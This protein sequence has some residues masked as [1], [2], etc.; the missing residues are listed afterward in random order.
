MFRK[1]ELIVGL[2]VIALVLGLSGYAYWL[3]K[4]HSRDTSA[5]QTLSGDAR[6]ATTYTREYKKVLAEETKANERMDEAL[7]RNPAWSDQPVPN[8]VADLLRDHSDAPE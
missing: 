1:A 2:L 7:A 3:S 5:I 8:D 4:T 6:A